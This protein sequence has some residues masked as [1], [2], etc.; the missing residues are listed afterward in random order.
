M[1][2]LKQ[3]DSI[4]VVP[5]AKGRTT[6]DMD[7]ADYNSKMS[8]MLFDVCTYQKLTRDPATALEC[9][10]N[11]LLLSLKQS[12]SILPK[13][14]S[15]LRSCAGRTPLFCGWPKRHKLDVPL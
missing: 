9:R 5:T 2:S 13:L 3:D 11:R 7:C 15:H 1:R 8:G 10:T 6:V 4:V 12:G 14:Y